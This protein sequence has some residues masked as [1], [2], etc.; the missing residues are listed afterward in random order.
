MQGVHML[1]MGLGSKGDPVGIRNNL[2]A[3]VDLWS[4][5]VRQAASG[6]KV[7]ASKKMQQLSKKTATGGGGGGG[8]PAAHKRA[9][10]ACT[11][12]VRSRRLHGLAVGGRR[13][14]V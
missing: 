1:K 9:P 7:Q 12:Q 2:K 3:H 10:R 6:Q 11:Q 4:A 13:K 5:V 14:R 8:S